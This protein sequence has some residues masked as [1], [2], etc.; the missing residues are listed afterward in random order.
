MT[1]I[2]YI[3]TWQG[4]LYLAFCRRVE[5]PELAKSLPQV[6]AEIVA[7]IMPVVLADQEQL[8]SPARK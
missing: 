5:R 4:W 6:A 8:C 2:T 7:F 3:R 1:D